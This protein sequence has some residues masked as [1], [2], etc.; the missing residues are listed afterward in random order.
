MSPKAS[1]TLCAAYA[2]VVIFFAASIFV[3]PHRRFSPEENRILSEPPRLTANALLDGGFAKD[4][5]DFFA[6]HFPFRTELLKLNSAY[7]L[8]LGRLE[9][10][11]V[12]RG[13]NNNLIK[14]LEIYDE[15]A[16]KS[17]LK[18]IKELRQRAEDRGIST[19]FLCAPR[20]I[21]A[22]S[23]YTP[24]PL[25]SD[26]ELWEIFKENNALCITSL[27]KEKADSGEYVYF[28][29][30]HHWTPLGA[31]YAYVTLGERLGY[32][33]Y[34]L[35]AFN[36]AEVCSDFFGSSYSASLMPNAVPDSIIALR[37][38]R[39]SD[40]QVKDK[41]TGEVSGL[42]NSS[43]L[44]GTS[45]YDYFL[46]GNKAYLKIES[47]DKPRLVL[48][49]DSFAN[50]LVPFLSLHFNIDLIDPRYLRE[51][52]DRL[53]NSIYDEGDIHAL[54]ILYNPETLCADAG[55]KKFS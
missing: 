8:A 55:L 53:L 14:R 44:D 2:A 54:L 9:C 52:L 43:A 15:N 36:E 29:T 45:K 40:V 22:L 17:N 46:G 1:K 35:S 38:E 32:E 7:T 5:G 51:P 31:Y 34:P 26:T 37:C 27:L 42:Y 3:M 50:S 12:M 4:T 16:L 48:I 47:G 10:G 6:D 24:L 23:A 18:A 13:K 30:D 33:P 20:A 25:S 21:D 49:K 28:H 19:V 39:D 11:S 41:S